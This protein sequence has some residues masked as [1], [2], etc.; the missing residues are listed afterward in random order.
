MTTSP[1]TSRSRVQLTLFAEASPAKTSAP[2][3]AKPASRSA[4]GQVSFTNSCVSFAWWDRDSSSWRTSQRSFLEGW[5]SFSENWPKQGLMRNG[6]V[7]RQ[8]LWAPAT[9]GTA[10]GLLPTPNAGEAKQTGNVENWKRRQMAHAATGQN[11]QMPLSVAVKLPPL[12]PDG[13]P[14]LPTP[15][16]CI[17]NDG[18]RP[19]TWMARRERVKLTANNGNGM[20]MPLTIAAQ[21]LP[22]P[23]TQEHKRRGPNS[24]QQGLSNTEN[25]MLPTP[26]VNDAGNSTLPPSLRGRDSLPGHLMRSDST[27]TGGPTDL[28][29]SFVEEMMGFPPGWTA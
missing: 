24:K 17:A 22:T 8:V 19:E 13:T 15:S 10:G 3:A 4:L 18:E 11:L 16:A 27:P 29:P 7:F 1:P 23:T 21:L 20:G 14:G 28:N 2:Q 12:G 5:T 26:T 25:W 9:V 6:H